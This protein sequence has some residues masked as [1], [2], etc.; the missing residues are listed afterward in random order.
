MNAA[1]DGT[2]VA[3]DPAADGAEAS[4]DDDDDVVSLSDSEIWMGEVIPGP[5][6]DLGEETQIPFEM[7]VKE[8]CISSSSRPCSKLI[9]DSLNMYKDMHI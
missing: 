6:V 5:A 3:A 2:A 9:R 1:D 7:M 8:E 4:H